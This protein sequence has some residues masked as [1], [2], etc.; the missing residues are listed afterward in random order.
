[1]GIQI[2]FLKGMKQQLTQLQ[3]TL[4][5]VAKDVTEIKNDVKFLVG[6]TIP[7]LLDIKYQNV[8]TDP[9]YSKIF[10]DLIGENNIDNDYII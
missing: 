8:I 2:Q 1:M 5:S 9:S 3:D 10:I 4:N 6:K 7:E